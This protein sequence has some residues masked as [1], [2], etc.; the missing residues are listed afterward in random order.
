MKKFLLLLTVLF[1]VH[2]HT[3]QKT[4][5]DT[6]YSQRLKE[7]RQI[8]IS[9][10]PSYQQNKTQKYPLLILLDGDFL[11][12]PFYGALNYGYYCCYSKHQ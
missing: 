9:L 5:V 3:A 6:I 7:D 8:K 4:I 2:S 1:C 11:F 12:D 10:P